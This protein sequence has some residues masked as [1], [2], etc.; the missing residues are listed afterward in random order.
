MA[1]IPSHLEYIFME[2]IKNAMRATVEFS[3]K[4]GRITH[5][6]IEIDI[7]ESE[8]LVTIRVRDSGGGIPD[9]GKLK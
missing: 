2:I 8:Q 7:S 4:T 9:H 3:Q 1:Y 6:P 5:P